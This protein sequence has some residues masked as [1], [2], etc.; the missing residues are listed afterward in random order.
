MTVMLMVICACSAYESFTLF[1]EYQGV[2][3]G[4]YF[5]LFWAPRHLV[6]EFR[7]T[8]AEPE[9]WKLATFATSRDERQMRMVNIFQQY[10]RLEYDLQPLL[11]NESCILDRENRCWITFSLEIARPDLGSWDS[12]WRDSYYMFHVSYEP[13]GHNL[14]FHVTTRSMNRRYPHYVLL[15]QTIKERREL[16]GAFNTSAFS[17]AYSTGAM[18]FNDL[19]IRTRK[20][21]SGNCLSMYM[22]WRGGV[23]DPIYISYSR[24]FSLYSSDSAP[25][26]SLPESVKNN[27]GSDWNVTV[28]F[29]DSEAVFAVPVHVP[30]YSGAYI[31]GLQSSQP[32][33]VP[34]YNSYE[35]TYTEP[36]NDDTWIVI[37]L[38]LLVVIC[39]AAVCS[40]KKN[41]ATETQNIDSTRQQVTI[42]LN[43]ISCHE[44]A[45]PTFEVHQSAFGFQGNQHQPQQAQTTFYQQN[46]SQN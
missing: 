18:N 10:G 27:I 31:S 20:T 25:Y 34:T 22:V 7:N 6:V 35:Y 14:A 8:A 9:V 37:L 39:F 41:D 12:F 4:L 29:Q 5:F 19:K 11:N 2:D 44:S 46:G 30:T 21:I 16:E 23:I 45:Q 43:E 33:P 24:N 17:N 40:R 42:Q 1:D 38:V 28:V 32:V 15:S 26:P 13:G 36:K 3:S